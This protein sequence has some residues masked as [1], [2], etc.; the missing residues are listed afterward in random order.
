MR[1]S[2]GAA[3]LA[4][5]LLLPACAGGNDRVDE[6]KPPRTANWRTIAT[7][8]DRARIRTWRDAWMQA[9]AEISSPADRVGL[10]AE[11]ALVQPDA[12]LAGASPPPGDY[13][14]RVVKLGA[15]DPGGLTY[16]S[17]PFFTCRITQEG[18]ALA[19]AKLD[20]S[21][22]PT[23]LLLPDDA[24]RRIFLGTMI[25]GDERRA[26]DYGRDQERDVA[27]VFERIGPRR[28]R[29]VM[30]FPHWESKLD[31]MELVPAA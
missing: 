29:L 27:G 3:A 22:R 16:V 7:D 4:S 14:C 28:W 30:P 20:G 23:G 9:L 19:F 15:K 6:D 2:L 31:V 13:R 5:L 25:L 1:N 18:D 10:A 21:Q 26:L 24:G 12:A 11:G 8:A 17:Y